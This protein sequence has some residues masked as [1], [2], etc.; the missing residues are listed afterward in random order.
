MKKKQ[1]IEGNQMD[2]K[3][4]TKTTHSSQAKQQ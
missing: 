2:Q 1:Q 3:K 4:Q